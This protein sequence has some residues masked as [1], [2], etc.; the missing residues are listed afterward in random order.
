MKTT[1]KNRIITVIVIVAIGIGGFYFL[2]SKKEANSTVG[3]NL[4]MQGQKMTIYKS[5]NCSC[6]NGYA[7]EMKRQGFDVKVVAVDN[8]NAIK[9]KYGIPIDKQSCHTAIVD[10][11]FIEGHVPVKAVEKLLKER[12]AINGIGLPGMPLGTPGMPGQKRGPYKIYQS[13]KGKFSEYMTI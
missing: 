8:L 13:V 6:C 1:M 4:A 3:K 2:I 12:P 9:E 10:N 7:D 11:Y 5:L